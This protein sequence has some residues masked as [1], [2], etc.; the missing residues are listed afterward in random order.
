MQKVADISQF[1]ALANGANNTGTSNL[2]VF[3]PVENIDLVSEPNPP[4]RQ[5]NNPPNIP[6]WGVTLGERVTRVEQD[7][8]VIKQDISGVKQDI[9]EIKNLLRR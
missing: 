8:S 9:S 3:N 1:E 7:I 4:S 2:S 6:K 5:D